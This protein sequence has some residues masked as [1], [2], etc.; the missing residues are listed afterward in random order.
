MS[1]Q[2]LDF[3]N[4]EFFWLFL[5]IPII[6]AYLWMQRKKIPSQTVSSTS[7]LSGI[8]PGWRIWLKRIM[9]G[10]RIIALGFL[11]IALARPQ[12]TENNEKIS[13]E[14]IDIILAMDVST[15]MLARDFSPDRLGASKKVASDFIKSRPND[16]IGLVVFGG[17]SFTQ[18]PLTSDHN[19]LQ[20]ILKDVQ[21]G[22]IADGTAIGMG[23]ATSVDRLKESKSK[24]KVVILLTDG[25]NNRGFIDPLT[26]AEIAQTFGIR[27]YT[28][29][30]GTMG[31][32]P[33]PFKT[34]TGQ[35]IMQDVEVKIDEALLKEIAEMTGV[36]YFRAT[37]ERSL[38]EIYGE[39]DKLEKTKINVATSQKKHE[40][41]H[42][43]AAMAL[44]LISLET[45]LRFT[46]LRTWP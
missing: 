17:E 4:P 28:I 16:R 12:K 2:G 34:R 27:V 33:Y 42:P 24:S 32:A 5:L 13:T 10:F 30:V 31:R 46:L 21:S 40:H 36:K 1:F 43:Y 20:N 8:S 26:A 7:G 23:L 6:I 14:G 22:L 44:L 29:G 18:C 35:T 3:A 38:R 41:F 25:E 19:V 15:S 39:I 9:P 11:I 45:L 37:N